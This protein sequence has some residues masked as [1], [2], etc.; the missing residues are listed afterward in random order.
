M[1]VVPFLVVCSALVA[2][3]FFIAFV[4]SAKRGQYDDVET[5]AIRMVFDEQEAN[6]KQSVSTTMRDQS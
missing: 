2:V 1:G 5:P 3:T 6:S 4:V